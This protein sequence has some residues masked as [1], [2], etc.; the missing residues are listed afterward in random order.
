LQH[1]QDFATQNY[2]VLPLHQSQERNN[3]KRTDISTLSASSAGEIITFRARVQ[4][5]RAQGA[6]M[7]FFAFRQGP[8]GH[9]IQGLLSQ[10]P[11]KVSKQMVKW[12]QGVT[13]ESIVIVTGQ[14]Q[15]SPEP[16]KSCTVKDAEIMISQIHTLA[17][18]P[19]QM[20]F[21][22]EDAA[23]PEAEYAKEDATFSRVELDTRLNARPFDLRTPTNQAIFKIQHGVS[24]L[25]REFLENRNFIEIHTP[26]LQGAATESGSSV[27]KV[28]YFKREFI[29]C[30]RARVDRAEPLLDVIKATLSLP[31]ARS[32]QSRWSS[33]PTL[34]EY[35]RSDLSSELRTPSLSILLPPN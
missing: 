34:S 20:P 7:V 2:G 13:S 26:K 29:K 24:R 35:T 32:W 3:S 18:A 30:R 11:E 25:F 16:I 14:V 19:S 9:T 21:V 10:K 12:A 31:K 4:N 6:K 23:R 1:L 15:A 22:F 5:S 33:L 8:G 17:E 27:F 28:D